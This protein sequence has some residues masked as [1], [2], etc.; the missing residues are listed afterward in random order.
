MSFE[1]SN[2]YQIDVKDDFYH[3]S[4]NSTSKVNVNSMF[5]IG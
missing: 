4:I 5:I 2:Q 1:W 3:I